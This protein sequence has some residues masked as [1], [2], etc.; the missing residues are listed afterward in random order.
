MAFEPVRKIAAIMHGFGK[1]WFVAGGWAVDLFLGRETRAHED[2]EVS[3]F[4]RDQEHI[5]HRLMAMGMEESRAVLVLYGVAAVSG[6]MAVLSFHSKTA[7]VVSVLI[8]GSAAIYF[9]LRR[10]R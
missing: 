10:S 8:V 3:I 6:L 7:G 2:I 9:S 5:H 1:P 4:R